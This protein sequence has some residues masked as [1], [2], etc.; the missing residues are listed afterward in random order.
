MENTSILTVQ[1]DQ[2]ENAINILAQLK[3]DPKALRCLAIYK[4]LPADKKD[5]LLIAMD[6]F[7]IGAEAGAKAR[8]N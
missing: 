2:V 3:D 6:A 5:I 8:K 4:K 1:P 7:V